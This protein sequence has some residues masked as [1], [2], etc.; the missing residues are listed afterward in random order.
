L[1]LIFQIGVILVTGVVLGELSGKL[2]LP[3]ISGYIT[4][5]IILHPQVTGFVE[6]G[7][8]DRSES[9][10]S[11]ALSFI[12]FSI[13]GQLSLDRIK[14]MGKNI[15][16][17]ALFESLLAFAFVSISLLL[18]LRF[19]YPEIQDW[20]VAVLVG[21]ILGSL[22]A[23]TDPSAIMAISHEDKPKGEV[24]S[25]VIGVAA[26][27]DI[28]GII[29]FTITL[30]IAGSSLGSETIGVGQSLMDL[31]KEIGGAIV[32]GLFFG[33]LFNRFSI[34]FEKK[35]EG[36]LIVIILTA[37]MLCYGVSA[38]LGFDELLGTLAMG[39]IVVNY[40]KH[41]EKIFSI[42][43]RYT[44]ELIFLVFFALSGLHLRFDILSGSLVMIG[45]FVFARTIG[46]YSGTWLGAW[47]TGSHPKVRKYAA[48]GLFPQGG[49]VIGL[50]LLFAKKEGVSEFS[51]M[52]I[53]IVIGA[54]IVHEL[55]GPVIAKFALRKAGEIHSSKS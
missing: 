26:F 5:G 10:I 29:L 53:S 24:S 6:P 17:I 45:I 8:V 16:L 2:G 14:K 47:A 37:L 15:L 3:K 50:A 30:S 51:S 33:F 28:I 36:A 54:A 22:A 43:D 38:M 23:P 40:H 27:D 21:L 42:I 19:Y 49:I 12:T 9:L 46:K 52:V 35:T 32:V 25:T 34:Y 11:I 1:N 31:G 44:D 13:G 18:S 55:I 41:H 39:M 20:Q 4:A 7:F 48:G